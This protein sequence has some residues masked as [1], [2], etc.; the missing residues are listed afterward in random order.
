MSTLPVVV[1]V[2]GSEESLRAAEWAAREAARRSAPLRIVS[3]QVP[4][5]RIQTQHTHPETVQNAVRGMAARNLGLAVERVNEVAQDLMLETE[6]LP[7]PPAVA[8]AG[9]GDG[10]G[11]LVVG[12]HGQGGLGALGRFATITGS[13]S[14]YAVNHARCPVIVVREET[15]A[16]HREVVVGV[17]DPGDTH[18]ALEFAFEEAALRHAGLLVAHAWNGTSLPENIAELAVTGRWMELD[19]TLA[20]WREKYPAVEVTKDVVHDQPA[21]V[22]SSLSSRADLLVIGKHA[23]HGPVIGSIQNVVLAHA[24]CPVAV[25]PS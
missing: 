14:R 7:A 2:D 8:V 22:L 21:R 18:G 13:V 16:V 20:A 12:A 5:P 24:R 11:V 9:S 1:A 15:W 17:R 23:K 19:H 10:A 3:A 25:V 6:L 4:P